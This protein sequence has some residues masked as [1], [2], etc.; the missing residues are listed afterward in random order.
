VTTIELARFRIEDAAVDRLVAERPAMVEAMR[1]RFP[2]CPAAYLT[3]EDDGGWL[4]VSC[5]AAVP[6]PRKRPGRSTRCPSAPPGSGTSARLRGC[7]TS[8]SSTPGRTPPEVRS[9]SASRSSS[10]AAAGEVSLSPLCTAVALPEKRRSTGTSS[11]SGRVRNAV[12]PRGTGGVGRTA[13]GDHVP[14]GGDER[15]P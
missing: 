11:P 12:N 1:R 7:V 8:K 6:K 15:A 14:G 9:C 5:G 3:R 4:D 10:A 13:L 2:G